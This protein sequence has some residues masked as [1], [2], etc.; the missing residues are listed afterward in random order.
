M[1]KPIIDIDDPRL[2]KALAHPIRVRIMGLLEQ[3]SMSPKEM[4]QKLG[5]P[6]EN[7]SY[8]VRQLRDFGLIR[9]ERKRQVRGAVE[10]YYRAM[11]RP[12]ITAAAWEQLPEIVKE[13]MTGA[14]LGQVTDVVARAAEQGKFT[15]PESYLSRRPLVVDEQGYAEASNAITEVL[16]RLAAIEAESAKRI[17]KQGTD[18]IPAVVVAMLFD[19]PEPAGAETPG[20][21]QTR[22]RATTAQRS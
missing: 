17:R 22:R 11:A 5:M 8:H 12:R 10:H 6:I 13:A 1:S 16:E 15:R 21:R 3:R 19:A 2:V 7:V 18:E 14:N 20:D 9:L 4:A